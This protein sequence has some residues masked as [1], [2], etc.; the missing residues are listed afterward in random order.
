MESHFIA[1]KTSQIHYLKIGKGRKLLFCFHG[2]GETAAS[3]L[4]FEKHVADEFTLI[5]IDFPFHGSTV[6]KEGLIFTSSDLIIIMEKI[7]QETSFFTE[8]KFLV[9]Y[10]MGG[11]VALDLVT[12]MPDQVEKIVLLAPD[13]LRI[14]FWYWLSTQTWCGNKLFLFTMQRPGWFFLFLKGGRRL[15]MINQSV[16][17]FAENYIHD[18]QARQVL[19][20]RWTTMRRFRPKLAAIK[21]L[22]R[23]NRIPIALLYGEFDRIIRHQRAAG[24]KEG[25]E[26]YCT[27]TITKAG[28]QLLQEKN[29]AAIIPLLKTA[30]C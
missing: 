21:E 15:H 27:I 12:Q 8:K 18:K 30:P 1:Y 7:T 11:R 5:A 26:A 22:I 6:W 28:H 4:F 23:S 17:K 19:Y 24:F 14:S 9:G 2:Y 25:I 3:F 29:A 16:F 10:S 20:E 13:G